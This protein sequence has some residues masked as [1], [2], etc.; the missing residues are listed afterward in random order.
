MEKRRGH[1]T[2]FQQVPVCTDNH[3][4]HRNF[5]RIRNAVT[6]IWT[7][8]ANLTELDLLGCIARRSGGSRMASIEAEH[9]KSRLLTKV[10]IITGRSSSAV[11]RHVRRHLAG[12]VWVLGSCYPQIP[13]V[14]FNKRGRRCC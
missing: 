7:G 13:T 10:V 3:L 2:C 12:L 4:R 6:R 14:F 11:A 9:P 1:E 5:A 8:V